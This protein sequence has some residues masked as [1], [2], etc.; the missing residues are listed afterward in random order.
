MTGLEERA[1]LP[2]FLRADKRKFLSLLEFGVSFEDV[3]EA[4]DGSFEAMP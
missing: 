4:L 3:I 1:L 2:A